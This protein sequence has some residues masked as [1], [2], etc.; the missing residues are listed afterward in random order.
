MIAY[1]CISL[2][3]T[4]GDAI[5]KHDIETVV[6]RCIFVGANSNI[7]FVQR[8]FFLAPQHSKCRMNPINLDRTI[9]DCHPNFSRKTKKMAKTARMEFITAAVHRQIINQK[10]FDMI[11]KVNIRDGQY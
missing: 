8:F 2:V 4:C 7:P 11:S 6:F 10:L 3:G 1:L 9:Q 5:P